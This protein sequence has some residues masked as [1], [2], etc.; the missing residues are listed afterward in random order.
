MTSINALKT[1][2]LFLPLLTIIFITAY[3]S[4]LM[5]MYGRYMS[6]DSYYS[7]GFLI[8][9]VTAFLIW[10]K[11]KQIEETEFVFSWWGLWFILAAVLVHLLGTIL[12]VFSISGFS[13]FFLVIG[14]VLFIFGK[15]ITCV[16]FF[17]LIYLVFMF[18]VP[19]A[20]GMPVKH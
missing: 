1:H 8:P 15:K 9:F 3:H 4:T 12:Y 20:E 2:L 6:T 17:P 16:I 14:I 5:W 7:H 19:K 13:I 10:Q 11:R 18:P